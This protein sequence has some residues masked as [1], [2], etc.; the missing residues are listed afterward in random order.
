M[1]VFI[2]ETDSFVCNKNVPAFFNA[3][4]GLMCCDTK[5]QS[6]KIYIE[7]PQ[8]Y[9]DNFCVQTQP[10]NNTCFF[11]TKNGEIAPYDYT[12]GFKVYK[13]C[14]SHTNKDQT[15]RLTD[16]INKDMFVEKLAEL[17]KHQT[18]IEDLINT[19][20][21]QISKEK[22]LRINELKN[23]RLEVHK[24]LDKKVDGLRE[25]RKADKAFY[26][27]SEEDFDAFSNEIT[28]S[29]ESFR[30]DQKRGIEKF[31]SDTRGGILLLQNEL[32]EYKKALRAFTTEKD[33]Y[34]EIREV[35]PRYKEFLSTS[36]S[37]G[38]ALASNLN[39]MTKSLLSANE[40]IYEGIKDKILDHKK[41]FYL[42]EEEIGKFI[43][44]TKQ[45]IEN[46][47]ASLGRLSS[48]AESKFNLVLQNKD[49]AR[50]NITNLLRDSTYSTEKFSAA[51]NFF[52]MRERFQSA[53]EAYKRMTVALNNVKNA[54]AT[55]NKVAKGITKSFTFSNDAEELLDELRTLNNAVLE[56]WEKI[57]IEETTDQN[58]TLLKR[59]ENLKDIYDSNRDYRVDATNTIEH[60]RNT[61]KYVQERLPDVLNPEINCEGIY[62]DSKETF[63]KMSKIFKGMEDSVTYNFARKA[64]DFLE[65][66]YPEYYAGLLGPDLSKEDRGYKTIVL[67]LY[68][69][70]IIVLSLLLLMLN[71]A[72]LDKYLS[73]LNA[74]QIPQPK[75]EIKQENPKQQDINI[76]EDP[77]KQNPKQDPKQDP[78]QELPIGYESEFPLNP[79]LSM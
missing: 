48:G 37:Q 41:E 39:A 23:H 25:K 53:S 7:D 51:E 59:R 65:Y 12:E 19:A 61:I 45:K 60:R 76:Q 2:T 73:I 74:D 57:D 9:E 79:E 31:K 35:Y 50:G 28:E 8:K 42:T 78:N 36:I 67:V 1:P 13:C 33:N 40:N 29:A 6:D 58:D 62:N 22:E 20:S 56:K 4:S 32:N 24:D 64:F 55:I 43:G 15:C 47:L 17:N 63:E 34:L 69:I 10:F 75:K 16:R 18:K 71:F 3:Q 54:Y 26:L 44:T 38:N 5:K 11:Q 77:K 66:K 46:E 49:H 70:S 30:N 72:V 27:L 21:E 68:V 52:E 14:G